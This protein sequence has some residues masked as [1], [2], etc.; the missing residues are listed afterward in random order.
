[1]QMMQGDARCAVM[2]STTRTWHLNSAEHLRIATASESQMRVQAP[3]GR[4]GW[5][6]QPSRRQ[7]HPKSCGHPEDQESRPTAELA[8]Q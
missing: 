5:Q 6:K 1:M 3:E 4:E 8:G 7:W 2:I